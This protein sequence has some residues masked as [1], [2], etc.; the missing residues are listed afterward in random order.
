MKYLTLNTGQKMPVIGL[1][2]W[3]SK[4]EE[5]YHAV[6]WAI[7]LGYTHFDCAPIYQNQ[8]EIGM[9]LHDA[10][11]EDGIKRKDLFITSK[12]WNDDH[13]VTD[14]AMAVNNILQ[15]LQLDYLDLLLVHWPVAQ[16]KGVLFPQDAED[17]IPLS[18]LPLELT[19]AEMEKAYNQNLVHN[20]GTANFGI[21]NLQNIIEKS[22][23]VPAVNQ[24]ESHPYLPQTELLEFCRKNNIA[25][26]AYSPLGTSEH[27]IPPQNNQ[28][29]FANDVLNEIAKRNEITVAQVLLAWQI[30]RGAAV[31][32]K[33]TDEKHLRQNMAAIMI[34]LDKSDMEKIDEISVRHRFINGNF[35]AYGNYTPENIFA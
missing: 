3:K 2:T 11:L 19:W 27:D 21:K 25:F 17:M 28:A 7:K 33:S 31:I 15:Q 26:T 13:S 6:R 32:P 20:I 5:V 10:M 8:S 1:G 29:L 35:L 30:N 16:K 18:E 23:V 4:P 24:V 14:V 9:A 34:E 22:S 12:I